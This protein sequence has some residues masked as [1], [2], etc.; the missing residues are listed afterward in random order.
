MGLPHVLWQQRHSFP[1]NAE[2]FLGSEVPF[3]AGVSRVLPER[4]HDLL[5]VSLRRYILLARMNFHAWMLF[6]S[7]WL[8]FS[9]TIG[10]YNILYLNGWPSKKGMIDYSGGFVIHLSVRVT[11][12]AATYW[13][14]VA[15]LMGIISGSI[16]WYTMMVLHQ[17]IWLLK[18]VDDTMAVF[19]THAVAR[20]LVCLNIIMTSVICLLSKLVVPLR[21]TEDEL[22]TRDDAIHREEAYALWRNGEKYESEIISVYDEFLQVLPNQS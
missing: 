14:R 18:Q 12:F 16:P 9:Y 19:H 5:P 1:W 6:V 10:A 3:V 22:Q 15:I 17:K 4:Y 8:S 11:G 2:Y 21:L 7:L 13:G 20:S